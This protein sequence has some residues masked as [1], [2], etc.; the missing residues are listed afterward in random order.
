MIR[1]NHFPAEIIA[2]DDTPANLQL[3]EEILRDGGYSV[4]AF[5][6]GQLALEAAAQKPPDL[7]MLDVNMPGMNGY[8]T[9]ERFKADPRLSSIPIIFI[10][11]FSEV[12]D[13]VNAFQCGGV[14]Y[15]TKPFHGAEVLARLETHLK[16]HRLQQELETHNAHLE[17]LVYQR[18]SELAEAKGRLAILDKA[19]SDFLIL[20]SH[21]LRTPLT[22]LLG[23]TDLIFM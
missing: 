22:G 14:D 12:L 18:T 5:A 21:E 17:E 3:L 6:R 20:I 7:I 16:L 15:V 2:V 9:C 4:R 23:V 13:K 8:E 11:A 19:K 1:I 10:S